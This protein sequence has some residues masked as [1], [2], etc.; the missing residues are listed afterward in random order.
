MIT[1]F[2]WAAP[3]LENKSHLIIMSY[4]TVF[5]QLMNRLSTAMSQLGEP[6]RAKAY[7]TAEE[8]ILSMTEDIRSVQDLANQ[9]GIGPTI[10]TKLQEYLDTGKIKALEEYENKPEIKLAEIYGIGP[11]KAKELVAQ[12]ITTIDE[13]RAR[14]DLLNAVQK[15][16]IQY[17]EDILKRIPRKEIDL[18]DK[19]LKVALKSF[20]ESKYEIVGSYRRE[21]SFSGDI[22]IIFTSNSAKTFDGFLDKLIENK[23]IVEVLSRGKHK[24]LVMAKIPE[25]ETYRRVDLL[26]ATPE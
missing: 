4:N 11:K 13:L 23:I 3:D 19:H 21:Q 2:P 14:P 22:D 18:Y 20:P 16:G 6:M 15:K 8:S 10:K 12:G 24:W 5:A 25:S 9:P 17:Y 1:F 7:K 26:F